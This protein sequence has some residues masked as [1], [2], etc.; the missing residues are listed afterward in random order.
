MNLFHL[1]KTNRA[2]LFFAM[3][4]LPTGLVYAQS[5]R[6]TVQKEK[7]IEEV[8]VIGY[9][10]QKKEAVTGSVV[11]VKGET[12]REVPT[13]NISQALQSKSAGVEINQT[14]SKPGATM[15][16]R[17]RGTRSLTET[18]NDPLIVLDGIPFTGSLGDISSRSCSS[19]PSGGR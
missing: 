8:V 12:L 6:D 2:A 13:V 15:K 10:T 7:Q 16:I 9:G 14:S 1:S 17:I 19:D 11:T 3:T 5:K 4:L 18:A